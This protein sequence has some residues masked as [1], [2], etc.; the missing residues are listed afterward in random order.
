[1]LFKITSGIVGLYAVIGL[2]IL[3]F[4]QIEGMLSILMTSLFYVL[5][6]AYGAF[7]LWMR[8]Q[9][10]VIILLINFMSQSIR[11]VGADGILPNIVPITVSFPIGEFNDNGGYLIDL[12]P[13]ALVLLLFKLLH[14]LWVDD[15]SR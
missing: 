2:L 3:T 4:A 7:G 8:N 15:D 6:P 1:M 10:V 12:F 14:T 11:F 5:I 9:K 13:I